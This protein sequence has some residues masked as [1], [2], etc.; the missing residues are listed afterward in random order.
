MSYNESLSASS[1][2]PC[3]TQSQW[4]NAPWNEERIPER[5]FQV[6]VSQSLSKDTTIVT[7]DYNPIYDDEF[8]YTEIDTSDTHWCDAFKKYTYTP[9][10]LLGLFKK[11]LEEKLPTIENPTEKRKCKGLI[12]DCSNWVENEFDVEES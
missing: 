12:E 4:D 10:E 6:V 3:M 7:D 8:G 5:E 2:Y 11:Y 9:L 1:N